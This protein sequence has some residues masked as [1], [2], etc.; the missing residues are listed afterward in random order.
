[1]NHEIWRD[2][3]GFEGKYQVSNLGRVKSLD[4]I[5]S[6]GRRRTGVLLKPWKE[7]NGYR[8]V[9]IMSGDKQ[10]R[11]Y[12]HRLVAETFIGPLPDGYEVN[13]KDEDKTNNTAGNLEYLTHKDN[14]NYGTANERRSKPVIAILDDGQ[15]ER[16]A[17]MTAA[18]KA[19]GVDRT[20]I[21]EAI[22][23]SRKK[24]DRMWQYA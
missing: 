6:I 2:V 7:R 12:V 22:H 18:G 15:T 10:R 3:P 1:M 23:K 24:H 21:R 17:S 9:S 20:T 14:I 16:Y 11:Y 13:H 5:D 19:F 4:R 8:L